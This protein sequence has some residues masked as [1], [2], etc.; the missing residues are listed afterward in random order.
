MAQVPDPSAAHARRILERLDR[1]GEVLR[2]RGDALALL[3]LGSVGRDLHRLDEHSDLDFFAV[4]DDDAKPRYLQDLDWLEAAA[5][6]AFSFANTA[7]GRKVLFDDGLYGEYAVFTL[8][9]L[10]RAAYPPG[11]V[12]WKRAD[13]PD[14]LDVPA[15]D[16][17]QEPIDVPHQVGE[18]MTNLF[19]GLHRDARGETLSAMRLIQVHAVDRVLNVLDLTADDGSSRQDLF[20]PE[21]G[22]E[23]RYRGRDL[24]LPEMAAGYAGNARAAR[25]VLTWLQA[26]CAAHLDAAL[27]DAVENLLRDAEGSRRQDTQP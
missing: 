5:P 25:A 16:A 13:A 4:V 20:A 15:Q 23:Q 7:D 10:R 3:G 27:V 19:V 24:P 14:G 11:R 21:R 2:D 8:A 17:R 22:V 12:V 1:I 18:A 9:E 6:V 26:H